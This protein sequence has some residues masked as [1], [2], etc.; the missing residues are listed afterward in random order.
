MYRS[1][2]VTMWR[3]KDRVKCDV[4]QTGFDMGGIYMAHRPSSE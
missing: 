4:T 1:E 2:F 3:I